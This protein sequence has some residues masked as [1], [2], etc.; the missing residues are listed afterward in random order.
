MRISP[1][2]SRRVAVAAQL[3]SAP[4]RTSML[5]VIDHL[6]G[7]Q[8]DPT[9][10]VARSERLVLWSRLGNYDVADLN[11][12][13]FEDGSLFEWWA[14]ILPI[15]DFAIHREAMRRHANGRAH[16]PTSAQ[17]RARWMA[18]NTKFR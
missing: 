6:G 15:R 14:F 1:E 11:R 13:L 2:E 5:D 18:A 10:A 3:L 4:L 12:A 16:T 7:L 8:M 17:Y 9:S